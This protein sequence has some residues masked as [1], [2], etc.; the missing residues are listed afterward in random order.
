MNEIIQG[1]AL[2]VL[3]TMPDENIDMVMT[4]PPYW[5]LRNYGMPSQ[6]GLEPTFQKYIEKLCDIFDE[7]KR[8]LKKEGTCWVNLG[9]TYNGNKTGYT[10]TNKNGKVPTDNL[11]KKKKSV[12]LT[13]KSLC[14]IP[15]RFAIEMATRGWILRNEIIWHKPNAMPTSVKD[16]FTVDFEKLFFF[17]KNKK[18]YF[19]TQFE[20]FRSNNYDRTRMANARTEYAGK[21]GQEANGAIKTQRAFVAGNKQGRNKRCVWNINTKPYT[22]AHFA[23]YPEELCRIPINAGCPTGGIILDP[24]CGS[25]TTLKV[26]KELGRNYIGIEL[27]SSYIDIANK[28]I[29]PW[30]AK[31][32]L[33]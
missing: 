22:G 33:F 2:E 25:G 1:D 19:E 8:V 31:N 28:R 5:N 11:I 16:R 27:N 18:Y 10:D 32:R 20:E 7:V 15:S 12:E 13:E 24:F 21:W 26:A 14:Q 23:V 17:T 29:E 3:R 9:D 30:L 4:S 6:L